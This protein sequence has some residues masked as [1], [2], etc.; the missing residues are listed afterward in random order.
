MKELLDKMQERLRVIYGFVVGTM[1]QNTVEPV[2]QDLQKLIEMVRAEHQELVDQQIPLGTIVKVGEEEPEGQELVAGIFEPV[3]RS[4]GST[5]EMEHAR[6]PDEE[7]VSGKGGEFEGA[8]ASGEYGKVGDELPP[9]VEPLS[10]PDST[11]VDAEWTEEGK[12]VETTSAED[13]PPI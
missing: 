13:E 9:V 2:V 12:P 1:C 3:K 7:P 8:G 11:V 4:A 6:V 10:Q 5:I